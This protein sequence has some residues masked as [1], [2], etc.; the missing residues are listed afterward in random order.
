[1]YAAHFAAA[2]AIKSRAPRAPAWLLLGAAFV[3]DFAWIALARAGI[4]SADQAAFFDDW[5]HSLLSVVIE[6]TVAMALCYRYGRAV[7]LAVGLAV[8]SHFIL[9][10]PI[11][12]KPLALYPRSALH[13]GFD[14]W[15]W[16]A[17]R[18]FMD[19][20]NYWWIQTLVVALLLTVY[21]AG[22]RR[23]AQPPNLAAA[24]CVAI[25]GLHLLI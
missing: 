24:S 21:V 23:N 25:G 9:D 10:L 13:L 2:L 4:E 17:Q 1:M 5:S 19:V 14:A 6:A 3:P 20:T 11:H 16:G 22:A 15:S 8:A 12:P 7:C 18:P